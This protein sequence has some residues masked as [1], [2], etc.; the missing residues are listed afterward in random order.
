MSRNKTPDAEVFIHMT[1]SNGDFDMEYH[2][3]PDHFAMVLH[4]LSMASNRVF[5]TWL[6]KDPGCVECGVV[7]MQDW[8]RKQIAKRAGG[9]Q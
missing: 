5:D 8:K 2:A 7:A 9:A 3:T 6:K 4:A 1:L